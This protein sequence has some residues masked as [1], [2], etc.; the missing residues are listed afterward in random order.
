MLR[1][2][3]WI[4]CCE[5]LATACGGSTNEPA[6]PDPDGES[7]AATNE[8]AEAAN[9]P[10]PEPEPEPQKEEPKVSA[11]DTFLRAGTAYL[12]NFEKS[13]VGIAEKDKCVNKS[14]GDV[15]KE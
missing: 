15:A 12:L 8:K 7:A 6:T 9:E 3:P 4:S 13:D 2:I 14:K 11:L 1:S 10:E 5:A